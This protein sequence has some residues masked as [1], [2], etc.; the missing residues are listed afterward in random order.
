LLDLA[1]VVARKQL[2]TADRGSGNL[3]FMTSSSG[4]DVDP[5]AVAALALS[6]MVRVT[7]PGLK[8][9]ADA[10]LPRLQDKLW[11]DDDAPD[12]VTW[13]L[14]HARQ[15]ELL[16]QSA[17]DLVA[18]DVE[19]AA[20]R[21][22]PWPSGS[23][24]R[25]ET[26]V[27]VGITSSLLEKAQRI[28]TKSVTDGMLFRDG[29]EAPASFSLGDLIE[30][31]AALLLRLSRAIRERDPVMATTEIARV[32]G[33]IFGELMVSMVGLFHLVEDDEAAEAAQKMV[34]LLRPL[35]DLL[36]DRSEPS[37]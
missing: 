9:L 28:E 14:L 30:T 7:V 35:V 4:A 29:A 13:T 26:A 24:I 8:E 27:R 12:V 21:G 32:L 22:T 10:Y 31:T 6:E 37:S 25:R 19:I 20:A 34:G 16:Q 5:K 2:S 15:R 33:R 3:T 1:H 18:R 11:R 17:S 36:V 23:S